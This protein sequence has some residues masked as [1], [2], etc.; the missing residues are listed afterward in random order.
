MASETV[1]MI[2]DVEKA[3]AQK[4]SDAQQNAKTLIEKA[5]ADANKKAEEI[6]NEAK[7]KA[8]KI[9]EESENR[10]NDSMQVVTDK[11]KAIEDEIR[12]TVS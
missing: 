1:K 7:A 12:S 10:Y 9:K 6:I 11:T 3:A 5:K 4:V 2:E 8:Q